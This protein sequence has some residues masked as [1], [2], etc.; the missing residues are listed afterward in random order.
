[1]CPT[2]GFTVYWSRPR[3][4]AMVSALAF[5][6]TITSGLAT[7]C[8]PRGWGGTRPTSVVGEGG[9]EA[10]RRRRVVRR[11][12]PCQL[13]VVPGGGGSG[14]LS[15]AVV[16]LL[17]TILAL[18]LDP[19]EILNDLSP[20]GEIGL[21]LI[22]F[23]ETGLLV[24]LLPPRRLAPLHGRDPG[25]PGEAEPGR[26]PHRV[27]RRRRHRRPGGVHD[28]PEDG[29]A[30]VAPSR[31]AASSNGSSSTAPST[32]STNTARRRS[33]SRASCPSCA[34]SPR[35]SPASARCPAG[36]SSA[37]TSSA[38]SSGCSA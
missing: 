23:A 32:S 7:W 18:S 25:Q 19:K 20:Y 16:H 10:Y 26:H 3:K 38:R 36:R 28:R 14:R 37:S 31:F 29:P 21:I 13:R 6:S 34:R 8:G 35:S 15:C 33:C 2:L 9:R 30:P 11:S 27:L 12:R 17:S 24:G 22:I 4:P 5:D 1:M